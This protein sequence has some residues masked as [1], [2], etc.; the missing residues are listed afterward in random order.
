MK[1]SYRIM[2][3]EGDLPTTDE[4]DK[5]G[6]S[7]SKKGK[8]AK[9]KKKKSKKKKVVIDD[10]SE[11]LIMAAARRYCLTVNPWPASLSLIGVT[12]IRV[13]FD[14]V[15]ERYASSTHTRVVRIDTFYAAL[16]E[17]PEVQVYIGSSELNSLV[18][19]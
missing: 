11:A 9:K 2:E 13:N 12:R 15:K 8:K 6:R 14:P 16:Q 10:E 1:L 18:S 7:L 4:D 17:H 19:D 3:L 5:T